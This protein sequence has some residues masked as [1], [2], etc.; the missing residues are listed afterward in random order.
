LSITPV[1]PDEWKFIPRQAG[2]SDMDIFLSSISALGL[3]AG[4]VAGL[5]GVGGGLLMVP[6]LTWAYAAAGLHARL[7]H[8]PCP[9]HLHGGHR[10]DFPV[11]P[12]RPPR[13]RRRGLAHGAPHGAGHSAGTLLG[14]LAAAWLSDAGLKIFFTVFLF[15]AATQ[16]LLGFKPKPSRPC[17][18]GRA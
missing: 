12:A 5:L 9:G 11:Q 16:M 14:S 8:P 10:A 3:I 17:R 7:Q 6:V 15:Y 18:A 1:D 2:R 13:P 4:F